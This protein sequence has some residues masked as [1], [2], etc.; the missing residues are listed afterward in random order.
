MFRLVPALLLLLAAGCSGGPDVTMVPVRGTVKF[1]DGAVPKGEVATVQFEP[2]AGG[3]GEVRKMARGDIRPD[4]SFELSTVKP[5]DGAIAGKYKVVFTIHKTYMGRESLIAEKYTK[6][7][8][9]PYEV[10]VEPGVK[11]FEFEVEK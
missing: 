11:P 2:V 10:T 5:G 4:G 8:T 7:E 1:K 6:P 9:T 3:P